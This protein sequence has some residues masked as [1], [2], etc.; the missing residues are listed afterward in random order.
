MQTSLSPQVKNFMANFEPHM[1]ASNVLS[2]FKDPVF[3]LAAP[4][5]GSSLLFKT[6]CQAPD[7]WSIANESHQIYANF[8]HLAME[9]SNFDSG[10]LGKKHADKKTATAL[11]ALY[12]ASIVNRNNQRFFDLP[13]KP[14]NIIFLEKTPET[15]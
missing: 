6:L 15:L 8:P 14:K 13:Q 12:A 2:T 11:R 4:R 3:I 7:I 5:S 10:A 1:S 9:N